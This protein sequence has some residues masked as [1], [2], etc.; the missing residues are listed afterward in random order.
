MTGAE[1]FLA[2]LTGGTFREWSQ[3]VV[4][5]DPL[6]FG[7]KQAYATRLAELQADDP[8]AEA[9]RVGFGTIGSHEV[10]L[11]CSDYEFV[12]G[13][14]GIAAAERV[15][16]AFGIATVAR[17]PVISICQSG[18]TR[19]Q[20][21]TPAF[22][23][24]LSIGAAISEHREAGLPYLSYLMD[25]TMGGTLAALGTQGHLVWA[26]PGASISLTGPRVV[27][28]VTGRPFPR[29]E[30]SAEAGLRRGL[31]DDIVQ[32]DEL[33]PRITEWLDIVSPKVAA[34]AVPADRSAP[35]PVEA[36]AQRRPDAWR[37]VLRSRARHRPS[38]ESVIEASGAPLVEIRGDRAGSDD[39]NLLAGFTSLG[40][41]PAVA[42]G[43][44]R[45]QGRGAEVSPG[46]YRK[47]Q[48][49]ISIAE[50]LGLP[51]V[52]FIDT[53]GAGAGIDEESEGLAH[54]V[55]SLIR[56]LLGVR[57]PTVSVL[58]G[59]GS[60][61]GAIALVAADSVIALENA[62]LAPIAPEAASA[63]LFRSTE[64][65]AH[66]VRGQAADVEALRDEGLID[67]IVSEGPTVTETS[68]MLVNAVA[69]ALRK[70]AAMPP[71]DRLLAR[72]A[73]VRSLA[74]QHLTIREP[75]QSPDSG[76]S[77]SIDA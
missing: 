63:I 72:R 69:A 60:G 37:S 43:F 56:E 16:R 61:A 76:A 18:G 29:D 13:T 70:T 66:M 42:V 20:E 28:A 64:R 52:S 39:R 4:T 30:I 65:A 2:E 21:G 3:E 33:A 58:M 32:P 44:L 31:V 1:S 74:R 9:S 8:L 25:P 12:A 35:A 46:G 67:S 27:E 38:I 26:A 11:I 55:G 34:P 53:K 68:E 71:E 36:Q 41:E 7:E 19:M 24:M 10:A 45:P 59:E 48:R 54:S 5:A 14:L 57:I 75:A 15:A 49:A 6:A 23:K 50:E 77:R 47:A 22:I 17:R 62:W 40:G 73:N 51:L